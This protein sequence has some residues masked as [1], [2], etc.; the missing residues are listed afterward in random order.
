MLD[1]Q[2]YSLLF[3]PSA[4]ECFIK[5]RNE[6]FRADLEEGSQYNSEPHEF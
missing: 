6:V 4:L 3:F 5:H 2:C 1:S